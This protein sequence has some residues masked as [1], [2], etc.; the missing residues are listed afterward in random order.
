MD[1]STP[2]S[3]VLHHLVSLH[4][5]LCIESV[6]LSNY[7]ICCCPLLLLPS[8]F[9]SIRVFSDEWMSRIRWPKY[10]SL[11]FSISLFSEHSGLIPFRIDWFDFFAVQGALKHLL[12]HHNLKASILWHPAFLMIQRS[13]LY[14]TWKPQLWLDGPMLAEWCLC[15][16][17]HC[18]VLS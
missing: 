14:M 15:F 10:W 1:C 17:I 13:H 3:S 12:Q 11:N 16:W 6:M 18:L 5:F 7:L 2:D 4:N 9:P 8:I